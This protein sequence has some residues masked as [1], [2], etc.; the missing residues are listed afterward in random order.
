MA[1]HMPKLTAENSTAI[2]KT[3]EMFG[4]GASAENARPATTVVATAAVDHT[5]DIDRSEISFRSHSFLLLIAVGISQRGA[6][7]FAGSTFAI[8]ERTGAPL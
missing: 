8:L 5:K 7:T 6:L 2:R 3:I 4:S 1:G